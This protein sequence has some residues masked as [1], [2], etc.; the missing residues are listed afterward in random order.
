MAS[1]IDIKTS[2]RGDEAS[3]VRRKSAPDIRPD[4]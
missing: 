4:L 1:K 3:T 2:F